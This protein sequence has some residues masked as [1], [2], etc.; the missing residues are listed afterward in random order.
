MTKRLTLAILATV[1]GT[2]VAAGATAYVTTR[3]VLLAS[4]DASL[5]TRASALPE[6]VD[7]T[8]R[9]F[10]AGTP[11]QQDDRYVIRTEVGRTIG[12]PTSSTSTIAPASVQPAIVNAA[13]VSL[14]GGN[15]LRSVTLRAFTKA[16]ADQPPLPVTVT[17][18]GSA[19]GFDSLLEELALALALCGALGGL[20]SAWIALRVARAALR[21]LRSTADVIG[22][23]DERSL[24]RRVD[25]ERLPPELVPMAHR[26]NDM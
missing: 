24:D 3:S 5:V 14:P 11:V 1:W 15:R 19:A 17:F 21:P 13:F 7:E 2:L 4:L 9:P 23:I 26:L 22:A 18:S 12:R 6:L 20:S 10:P 8:G 25:T 16:S